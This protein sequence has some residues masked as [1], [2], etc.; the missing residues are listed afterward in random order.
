MLTED[1]STKPQL[2]TPSVIIFEYLSQ[3]REVD[4]DDSRNTSDVIIT[5]HSDTLA[6][7]IVTCFGYLLSNGKLFDENC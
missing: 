1:L 2:G 6:A 5:L 3:S 7:S 4:V